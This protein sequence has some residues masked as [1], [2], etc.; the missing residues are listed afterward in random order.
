MI[1]LTDGKD[2]RLALSARFIHWTLRT[3]LISLSVSSAFLLFSLTFIFALLI[4]CIAR[5]QPRCVTSSI[6]ESNTPF[7]A[8]LVDA[9]QLSWTTFTTVGYGMISPSTSSHIFEEMENN[10]NNMSCALMSGFL[11]FECLFGILFNS[12]AG[13]I[14]F[15]RLISFQNQAQIE[16]SSVMIVKFGKGLGDIDIDD[17]SSTDDDEGKDDD[18]EKIPCPV[19]KFRIINLINSTPGKGQIVNAHLNAVATVNV[20]N[21]TSTHSHTNKVFTNAL[22]S[23]RNLEKSI[24]GGHGRG[25]ASKNSRGA[26]FTHGNSDSTNV[27]DVSDRRQLLK[28]TKNQRL[29]DE[30]HL[31][32]EKIGFD[33]SDHPCFTHVW[34]VSHTLD[35]NSPLVKNSVRQ[36]IQRNNGYWPPALNEKQKVEN[37]IQFDQIL[38]S[39][40]GLSKS[41]GS[42]V[43]EN[44]V[45]KMSDL[46][47]GCQFQSILM[48]GHG[49]CLVVNNLAIDEIREQN[50]RK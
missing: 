30:P 10:R 8:R 34:H 37:S 36:Q 46:N 5:L 16:F 2:Q 50:F 4:I 48:E 12:L 18:D 11:S 27:A 45:Y 17:E 33:L 38:I 26:L 9:W 49:G 22:K 44:H 29:D 7:T 41:T 21:S 31:V 25:G 24:G 15:G 43:F 35:E 42:D 1:T 19:L 39:F 28:L 3:R 40:N 14:I 13:A 6:F 32:F 23:H 47:Y 20:N